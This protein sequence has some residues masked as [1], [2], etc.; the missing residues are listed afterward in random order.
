MF[1]NNVNISRRKNKMKT[2][3][4]TFVKAAIKADN[5]KATTH[6]GAK[7]NKTSL[8]ACVDMFGSI[9]SM[10]ARADSDVISVFTKAFAEDPLTALKLVFWC[11]DVRGGAGE[12]KVP[13]TIL[14]YLANEHTEALRK[15]LRLI[16]EFGRWDDYFVFE[17]TPLWKDAKAIIFAQLSSDVDSDNP[18][19]LG[20]WM[21]SIN[22]SSKETRRL[23]REFIKE[24]DWSE[25]RY[26]KMLSGLRQKIKIVESAMCSGDWSD[27]NYESVPSRAAM[28]YRKAFGKHDETRYNQFIQDV[29][30]GKKEI[31][32]STLYPYDIVRNFVGHGYARYYSGRYNCK[33][34]KASDS[35]T[36]EAQWKSLP[37]YVDPFNGLVMLDTSGSMGNGGY[38]GG[39]TNTVRPIDVALS[40]TL[41]I[42]ERNTSEWKDT[43]LTFSDEASIQKIQ[44]TTLYEKL[45]N[46]SK[47]KWDMSTNLQSSFELILKTGLDNGLSN[48][49]MPSKLFIVSDMQ[50]DQGCRSNKRTNLEQIKKKYRKAGYDMPQLVWWNV[51]AYN[52]DSPVT[53][54]DDNNALVSGASP[55][56][57]KSVLSG[58]ILTPTDV[59]RQTI[60]S[61]RY[62][63]IKI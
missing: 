12:R 54:D 33:V 38:Y 8:N 7:S 28:I 62:S 25:K 21:P 51:N 18:S 6:N 47:A 14:K 36:L 26:R 61:D 19:L 24:L 16:S 44:G 23:A 63:E 55:A 46:M 34:V 13:R 50:F 57:L 31:K 39:T 32:A 10:R 56:I 2:N 20:K 41:Y 49:D 52:K 15:N 11:R 53:V 27:I 30:D 59:M 58:D 22:T 17:G 35:K 37:D 42:A 29:V 3:T 40:L 43:F 1:A 4:S 48:E 45:L 60:D 9:A 5:T